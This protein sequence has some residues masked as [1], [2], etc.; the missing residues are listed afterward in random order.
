MKRIVVVGAGQAGVALC[1]KLRALGF[2]GDLDV[3]G[4]ETAP[5]YQRPPLSKDYLLGKMT[6]DRL[7]LRAPSFYND[8]KIRLH[9]GQPVQNIDA[10]ARKLTLGGR[11]LDYDALALTTGSTARRLPVQIGG[12]LKSVYTVRSLEDVD[13]MRTEFRA[14]AKLVVIGGGYIGL[15]AAAVAAKLGLNV[16]VV[17]M[18]P[19]ILQRVAAPQT[20]DY[21]RALHQKNGVKI[22]EGIGLDH[23]LGDGRVRAAQLTDGRILD[24]DFVIVGVGILPNI[25]LAQDCGLAIDNGIATDLLGQTSDPS[26]WAAGDCASFDYR[27]QRLRLESVQNAIDQAENTAANMLGAKKPYAPLPWFWSDQYDCKLQIAGLNT[28]Y[29][30][31]IT[32]STSD[33]AQSFWYFQGDQL[34]AVDA[35]NDPRAFMV[36]KRLLVGTIKISKTAVADHNLDLKTL[37]N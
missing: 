26:I 35:M 1:A 18:A 11:S 20:S 24:A 23:L 3:I 4:D 12:S 14:G 28:G 17:E 15:E 31:V 8:N 34:L 29:D 21:F 16:T 25:S 22:L 7:S 6:G 19:R 36:A 2:D 9:L 5:P 13:A 32:R 33:G 37:L 30:N 10:K 27:G